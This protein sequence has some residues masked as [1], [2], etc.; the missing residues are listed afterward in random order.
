MHTCVCGRLFVCPCWHNHWVFARTPACVCK[1]AAPLMGV[2]GLP[3]MLSLQGS[4]A[5]AS[6]AGADQVERRCWAC[7]YAAVCVCVYMHL[8]RSRLCNVPVGSW[9]LPRAHAESADGPLFYY[10]RVCWWPGP[11]T[12][13]AA[14]ASVCWQPGPSTLYAACASVCWRPGHFTCACICA[15]AHMVTPANRQPCFPT[16]SAMLAHLLACDHPCLPSHV[17]PPGGMP[18][19]GRRHH[20]RVQQLVLLKQPTADVVEGELG[21]KGAE[22][23]Q[24]FA[25]F[26]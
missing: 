14:C 4:L 5:F 20:E 22:Q 17:H 24:P 3:L 21:D 9:P 8:Q 11:S 16:L 23:L 2:D 12:L 19:Q 25:D 18:E 1:L 10:A 13:H 6:V 7:A 26:I 15:C